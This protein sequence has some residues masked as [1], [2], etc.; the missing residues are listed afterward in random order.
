[1]LKLCICIAKK[2]Q[3]VR[4]WASVFI[5]SSLSSQWD[6]GTYGS[7]PQI[8]PLHFPAHQ[9]PKRL[10]SLVLCLVVPPIGDQDVILDVLQLIQDRPPFQGPSHPEFGLAPH[11]LKRRGIFLEQIKSGLDVGGYGV[12]ASDVFLIVNSEAVLV[13]LAVSSPAAF[14]LLERF[15]HVLGELVA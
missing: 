3:A 2:F 9:P 6:I 5:N 13:L 12:E 15:L 14:M 8:H 10:Y 7:T 4:N 11:G 1:M